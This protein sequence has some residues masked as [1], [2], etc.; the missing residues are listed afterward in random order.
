MKVCLFTSIWSFVH[1]TQFRLRCARHVHRTLV[2]R[3]V[4]V[5]AGVAGYLMRSCQ[6]RHAVRSGRIIRACQGWVG[7]A[8]IDFLLSV[9]STYI[10]T[11][12]SGSTCQFHSQYVFPTVQCCNSK[13]PQAGGTP[14][15]E[16]RC[17]FRRLL[18]LPTTWGSRLHACARAISPCLIVGH[19]II[20]P[21]ELHAL[22]K[23]SCQLQCLIRAS[24][25]SFSVHH[26]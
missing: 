19:F 8:S 13:F 7:L 1:D 14:G 22:C 21:R 3:L 20:G 10:P 9:S 25:E 4:L 2:R 16:C 11:L 15:V 24:P 6:A 18:D 12:H 17:R 26:I 23:M 5:S